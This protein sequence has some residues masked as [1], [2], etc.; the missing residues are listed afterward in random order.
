MPSAQVMCS[1]E[2]LLRRDRPRRLHPAP[3]SA[4]LHEEHCAVVLASAPVSARGAFQAH[5]STLHSYGLPP[6]LHDALHELT[7][8]SDD[9]DD[10]DT[11]PVGGC[12]SRWRAIS[13]AARRPWPCPPPSSPSPPP[14]PRGARA[15]IRWGKWMEEGVC[16]R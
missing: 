5:E 3:A 15:R 7:H 6:P 11:A 9:D 2:L 1:N 16:R 4:W 8:S 13:S 12:M 14:Q 10:P